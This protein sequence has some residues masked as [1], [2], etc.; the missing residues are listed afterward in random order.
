MVDKITKQ[1][2]HDNNVIH[3]RE[4]TNTLKCIIFPFEKIFSIER[5]ENITQKQ[6]MREI[7]NKDILEIQKLLLKELK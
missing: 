7:S 2:G 1:S 4:L 6:N 5:E 3:T